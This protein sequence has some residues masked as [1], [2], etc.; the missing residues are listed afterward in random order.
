MRC[1]EGARML[2][3]TT[4]FEIGRQK[5]KVNPQER[6]QKAHEYEA[7]E[8]LENQDTSCLNLV[9]MCALGAWELSPQKVTSG[10]WRD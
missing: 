4:G 6:K 1:F 9:Q 7:E 5:S 3:S 2:L 8:G 10:Q